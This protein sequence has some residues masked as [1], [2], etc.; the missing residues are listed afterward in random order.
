MRPGSHPRHRQPHHASRQAGQ[1]QLIDADQ[2]EHGVGG[3]QRPGGRHVGVHDRVQQHMRERAHISPRHGRQPGQWRVRNPAPPE[4]HRADGLADHRGNAAD[5]QRPQPGVRH[6]MQHVPVLQD[7][8][9]RLQVHQDLRPAKNHEAE[10][11]AAQRLEGQAGAEMNGGEG[12][13]GLA[14]KWSMTWNDG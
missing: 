13:G 2:V 5:D 11:P 1:V 4:H 10:V 8:D 14:V 7:A 9:Q 12:H 3:K 6:A